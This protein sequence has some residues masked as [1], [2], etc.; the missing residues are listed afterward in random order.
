MFISFV[1]TLE[2]LYALKVGMYCQDAEPVPEP[3]SVAV[4]VVPTSLS[5][6]PINVKSVV[7]T[8]AMVYVEPTTK[9]PAIADTVC[10]NDTAALS[11]LNSMSSSNSI[12]GLV[13][14]VISPELLSNIKSLM[15]S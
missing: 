12:I 8:E 3:T 10:V 6:A 14:C 13:A 4:N 9:A 7:P 11:L 5:D 1:Y 15:S 2:E